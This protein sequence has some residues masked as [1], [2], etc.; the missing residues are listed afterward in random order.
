MIYDNIEGEGMKLHIDWSRV[1]TL[2]YSRSNDT[3]SVALQKV[4]K[5]AGVYVFGRKYGRK[6]EAL[7][8]G[9]ANRI[10]SRVKGQL[11]NLRLMHHIRDARAGKRMLLAGTFAPLPGQ[12]KERCLPL[13]ERALIRYFLSEGHDLVNISGT[14]LRQHEIDSSGK[15]PKRYF[16]RTIFLDSK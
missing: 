10:R 12:Q 1:V 8:V 6:F 2:K 9:R 3:Y 16:A 13:I 7:Y 4:P 5:K 15:Y 11:N 14:H